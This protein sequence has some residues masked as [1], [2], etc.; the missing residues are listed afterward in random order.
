MM[1]SLCLSTLDTRRFTSETPQCIHFQPLSFKDQ[2]FKRIKLFIPSQY[3]LYQKV[4]SRVHTIDV[5]PGSFDLF[6][7]FHLP[8]RRVYTTAQPELGAAQMECR[9]ERWI[10]VSPDFGVVYDL[11]TQTYG[12]PTASQVHSPDYVIQ[13]FPTLK[14]CFVSKLP[15]ELIEHIFSFLQV[16][17]PAGSTRNNTL[18]CG[19]ED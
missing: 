5:P 4:C 1:A 7:Y 19:R 6:I 17:T 15:L 10:E 2:T 11:L 9:V 3:R 12:M 8:S 13:L 16:E 18:F 14:T